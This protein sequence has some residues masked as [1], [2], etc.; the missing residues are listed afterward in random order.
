MND[1]HRTVQ[2]RVF[3]KVQGVSY[4]VWVRGV[5]TGLGLA[6]WVRNDRDGSVTALIAGTDAAVSTMIERLWK[7]PTGASVAKVEVEELEQRDTPAGFR[8]VA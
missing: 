4:R 1:H 3:G 8:I 5:A 2:V 7:G 6:G